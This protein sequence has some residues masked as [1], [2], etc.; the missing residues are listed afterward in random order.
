MIVGVDPTKV[1]D[2][3]PKCERNLPKKEKTIFK[4][5]K[6]GLEEA[7]EIRDGIY[8]ISGLGKERKEKLKT[9][10]VEVRVLKICLKGW[11]NFKDDK[12]EDISFNIENFSWIPAEVRTEIADYCRGENIEEETAKNLK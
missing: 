9:G 4:V 5:R 12:G 8:E 10:S 7:A 2:Y 6:V 11:E 3:I 1:H